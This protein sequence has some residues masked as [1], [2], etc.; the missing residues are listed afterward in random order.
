MDKVQTPTNSKCNTPSPEL[1]GIPYSLP[2]EAEN[3]LE[4]G[5]E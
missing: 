1:S 4:V 2:F 3:A 5:T